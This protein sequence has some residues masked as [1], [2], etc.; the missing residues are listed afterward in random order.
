MDKEILRNSVKDYV[1]ED[2]I[3]LFEEET[4][5]EALD[6]IKRDKR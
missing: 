4:V 5:E 2:Y 3:A 6:I 1:H